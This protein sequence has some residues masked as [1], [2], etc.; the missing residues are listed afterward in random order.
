MTGYD[1]CKSFRSTG[2][3]VWH[4]PD[5][6][7]YPELNKME[8][9]GLLSSQLVP[10]GANTTKKQYSITE[11]GVRAFQG[12]MDTTLD[13]PRERDPVH[14]KAAYFEWAKPEAARAQLLA[15]IEHYESR[16]QQWA[17]MIDALRSHTDVTL[18]RRLEHF[19]PESWEAITEYKVFSYTGLVA[20]AEQEIQ[21]A[22]RGLLL[23]DRLSLDVDHAET[24]ASSP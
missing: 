1:L 20:Q 5:S 13:Y 9:E 4:A 14:L 23:I 18:A 12:W 19:P 24:P 6:Q 21:W 11:A 15:H 22:E 10:W 16:L 3:L 8:A 17:D 2:G 7:I